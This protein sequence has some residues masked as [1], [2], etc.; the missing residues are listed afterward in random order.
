MGGTMADH[1]KLARTL[2]EQ[3]GLPNAVL[4]GVGSAYEQWNG[5]GWP[6]LLVGEEIP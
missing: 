5:R 4:D 6:G 3:L 1:A 2:A